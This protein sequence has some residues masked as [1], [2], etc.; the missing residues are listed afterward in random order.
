MKERYNSFDG[1]RAIAAI[2]ILLMHYLA[3]VD[4]KCMMTLQESSIVLYIKKL[5]RFLRCLSICFS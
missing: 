4:E 1:L 3:N 5:F 2:G